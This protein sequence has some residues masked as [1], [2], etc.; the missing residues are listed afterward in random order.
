MSGDLLEK[1]KSCP[2]LFDPLAD[3]A[4]PKK[5]AFVP[6]ELYAELVQALENNVDKSCLP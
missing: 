5:V 4:Q 1:L 3:P 6:Q 2:V